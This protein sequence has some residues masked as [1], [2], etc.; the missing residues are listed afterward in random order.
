MS[1]LA[2]LFTA[3][4]LPAAAFPQS[5][6]VPATP[7]N[8]RVSTHLVYLDVVVR[9]AAGQPVHGLTKSD[10]KVQ[11]DGRTQQVDFFAAHSGQPQTEKALANS[12]PQNDGRT[13]TN[14][15]AHTSNSGSINI[16]LFDLLN[17]PQLDQLYA[18]RQMLRFLQTLPPGQQ[19]AL[20]VLSGR[21]QMIQN[22]TGSSDQL[23]AAAK[24]ID[25]K[26][27]RLI[28]SSGE[29]TQ[30]ADYFADFAAAVGRSPADASGAGVGRLAAALSDEDNINLETRSIATIS[31]FAEI[32]RF[33]S[34]YP[35]R[36]NLLW[37]SE[38]FPLSVT[39]QLQYNDVSR[40]NQFE[41]GDLPGSLDAA[42]A[43]ANAQ[44]AVYPIDVAGLESDSL[45]ASNSG[46]GEVSAGSGKLNTT[47]SQSF[48]NR[49]QRFDLM[50]ELAR[51]T[52]GKAF[53]NTND[54][55]G[56]MQRSVEDGS[57]Y[58]TLA[59][60]PSNSNWDG[61][62]RKI[63]VDLDK[64]GVNLTYRRGYFAIADQTPAE[65]PAA[66]L[67]AALQPDVLESTMLRLT[68]EV[69]PPAPNQAALQLDT[70]LD[71]SNL[72]FS[73]DPN[74]NRHARV[75]VMLVAFND[76]G[77]PEPVRQTSSALN[78]DFTA[79]QYKTYLDSGVKFRQQLPLPPG[80]YRLR[81]G[82]SDLTNHRL[83]TLVV[84]VQIAKQG[85][86]VVDGSGK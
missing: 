23:A 31:A 25:A 78:L 8:L 12:A 7:T 72:A 10:F 73:A 83:G 44:I 30:D 58:Y 37:V 18:R 32:A 4:S 16:L 69:L 47:L 77:K 54:L 84:P 41:L 57:N 51:Q 40:V 26:D 45:G 11:E 79:A 49:R 28:R 15:P 2:L 81:L 42:N 3:L 67:N 36:K 62:F 39:A 34:G 86:P 43:I 19:L 76:A 6:P 70:T 22:F 20:F 75:L 65:G 29:K 82:V 61:K 59:Y 17:T 46:N 66:E 74:G 52:G 68:S 53:M 35:G 27:L 13:F 24:L 85:T 9:D 60:R 71:I 55:A 14:I 33:T 38:D 63:K 5:A 56:A 21:L 48:S 50:N 80:K 1:R 64:S